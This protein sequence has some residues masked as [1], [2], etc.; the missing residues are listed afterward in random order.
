VMKRLAPG[1]L[2]C[3]VLL[4]GV[5][6]CSAPWMKPTV[7]NIRMTTDSSGKTST[8]A[9]APDQPFYVYADLSD[10]AVSEIVE[11]RWFVV[12]AEGM[13]PNQEINRSTYSYQPGIAEIYFQLNPSGGPWPAGSYRVELYLDGRMVGEQ[14]F[15]VQ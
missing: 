10:L 3:F 1:V 15:T 5:L 9:Y 7:S 12:N 4:A 13:E 14:A 11:A 8:Q 6:A 2:A